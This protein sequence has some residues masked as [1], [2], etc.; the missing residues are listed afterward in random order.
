MDADEIRVSGTNRHL[1]QFPLARRF[2]RGGPTATIEKQ[3]CMTAAVPTVRLRRRQF[4][5]AI[6]EIRSNVD[7]GQ[8][9]FDDWFATAGGGRVAEGSLKGLSQINVPKAWICKSKKMVKIATSA[10][11]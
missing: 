9:Q 2:F 10:A 4:A 6:A 3:C 5:S 1:R 8:M 11:E 7:M